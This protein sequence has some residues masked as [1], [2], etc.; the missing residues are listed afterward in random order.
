MTG[1]AAGPVAELRPV[2]PLD[3]ELLAALQ[4]AAFGE[5]AG[6]ERWQA[7]GLEA[8]LATPGCLGLIAASGV[9]PLGFGLARLAAGEAEILSLGVVPAA[10][11]LGLGRALLDALVARLLGRG[12]RALFL[13]VAADNPG[14]IGLYAGAGFR[15]AGRRAGYYARPEGPVDALILRLDAS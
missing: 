13:E 1:A 12:A 6:T 3:A 7:S 15:R 8:L 14:A 4:A 10:R 2:G 9:Q 5:A 11:R